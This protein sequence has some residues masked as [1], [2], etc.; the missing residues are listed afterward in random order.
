M[1]FVDTDF[2]VALLKDDDWLKKNA[3]KIYHHY[4][5]KLWTSEFVVIELLLISQ[6]L[7]LD[8]EIVVIDIYELVQVEGQQKNAILLAANYIKEGVGVFDA[9]HAA[10]SD[11][12]TIISSDN[13]FDDL[14]LVRLKLEKE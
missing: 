9:I 8:P 1:P 13:V 10:C 14:G 4:K 7:K 2:L 12:D 6:R 11:S 5:G 3:L